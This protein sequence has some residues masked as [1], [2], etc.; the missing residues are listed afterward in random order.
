MKTARI[1]LMLAV[2]VAI[3]P[4]L[5]FPSSW[6]NILFTITG[7]ALAYLAYSLYKEYKINTKDIIKEEIFD[8]FLENKDFNEDKTNTDENN[9][10]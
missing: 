2:W 10:N 4:Y 7:L 5:G 1:L 9:F 3:L 6:K 8:N